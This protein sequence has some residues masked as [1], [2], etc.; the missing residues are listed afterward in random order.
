MKAWPRRALISVALALLGAAALW[1]VLPAARAPSQAAAPVFTDWSF[2]PFAEGQP[3]D[4]VQHNADAARAADA[5]RVRV[6][7]VWENGSLRGSDLDGDWGTW[8]D[9]Q[10]QPSASL[11]RRFDYLLTAL[12][13]VQPTDLRHWIEQEVSAQMSAG[14]ARQVLAVWDR[15]L[16]LQ[17][18]GFRQQAN[19]NDA[20]TWQPALAERTTARRQILGA[21]WAQAFY[22]DEE[23]AFVAFT[24]ELA[25]Q[26][27]AGAKP[28]EVDLLTGAP[29]EQLQ[30]QR[31]QQFGADAAERLRAED[32]SWAEWERRLQSARQQLQTFA[33]AP[34]LSALQR[35]QAQE[36]YLAQNFSG[37]ELVRARALLM[38]SH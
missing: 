35:S 13:E 5:A 28:A 21:D 16:Q 10:L 12:G 33:A 14:A 2:N 32:T 19:P 18:Q 22:G 11:R 38:A 8:V 37:H 7:K 31:V 27:A 17:Q 30:A 15:Y 1:L 25:A 9:N 29:S 34:E 24:E 6:V 26:R 36:T 23:R 4:G 20:S 3:L